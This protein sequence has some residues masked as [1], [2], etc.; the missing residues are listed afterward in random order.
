MKDSDDPFAPMQTAGSASIVVAVGLAA[1]A[2][3]L[4]RWSSVLLRPILGNT[5]VDGYL[6][7]LNTSRRAHLLAGILGPV[8]VFTATTVGVLM[9]IGVDG[10]TLESLVHDQQEAQTITTLNCIVT[11]MIAI[12]AALMIVNSFAAVTS[13]RRAE[14]ARLQL[15]GA[16]RE[17]V[18][19]VVRAEAAIVAGIGLALGLVASLATV[20]PY[21][22]ARD[23]GPLPNGQLWLPLVLAAVAVSL[24][25]VSASVAARRTLD[26]VHDEGLRAALAA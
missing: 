23:E 15:A 12:F 11:G 1:L 20:V 13:Q 14:F 9:M 8:V 7:V 16:T 10:R 19:G 18:S 24:T 4:L 6:A 25:L 17:N 22:I 2:P 3:V 21:S 26:S 5:S